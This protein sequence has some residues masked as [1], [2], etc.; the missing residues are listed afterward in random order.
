VGKNF[1]LKKKLSSSP[2]IPQSRK[3]EQRK[4][5]EENMKNLKEILM[6]MLMEKRD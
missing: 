4:K 2:F 5:T 3:L 1:K 6:Q